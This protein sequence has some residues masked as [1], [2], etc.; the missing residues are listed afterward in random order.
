[1][2]AC[3]SH[4]DR[5]KDLVKLQAGEYVSLAKVETALKLSPLVDNVCLYADSS[6]LYTVC[7]VVPNQ[8]HVE[9]LARQLLAG[10]AEQPVDWPKVCE[11][12]ALESAVLRKLQQQGDK[13]GRQES[14]SSP[15][16]AVK[17][18][19]P[20]PHQADHNF[21]NFCYLLSTGVKF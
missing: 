18:R 16:P 4:T 7:L 14:L 3:L 13:G 17:P 19:H 6:K 20:Y 21:L 5:R 12:A 2:V 1:M 11:S 10:G 9:A 15:I 8:K